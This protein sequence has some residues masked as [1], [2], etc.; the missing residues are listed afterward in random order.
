MSTPSSEH[1][2]LAVAIPYRAVV[3]TASSMPKLI[4]DMGPAAAFAWDELF[5]GQLRNQH[6]RPA[7]RR[8]IEQFL[9]W[10]A[11]HQVPIEMVT[12]GMI[13]AFMDSVEGGIPKKKLTMAALRRFFDTLVMRHVIV[14]NPALSVRT[15]RYEVV[16]GLTPEITPAQIRQLLASIP[17]NSDVDR[18]DAAILS[19]LIY[20]AARAGAVAK[21][22]RKHL[23]HDGTQWVLRFEEKGGK[24]REIPV[25]HDLELVLWDY[26]NQSGLKDTDPNAPLFRSG[27]AR[28]GRLTGECVTGTDICRMMK[29]RLAAAGQPTRLS[30]HSFRVATITDLLTQGVS[31]EDVQYLAGHAD[32][33]TTRLYDRRQR[34]ITRNVVERITL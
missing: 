15:E 10:L 12:P 20:T 19:T 14:L 7:Y 2:S 5:L 22:R 6:T 13:G 32:P 8:A 27:R 3:R 28:T 18:R 17:C 26:L 33:R 16:E 34:R 29:R 24:L 31:L 30:P 23:S 9:A 1:G 25:R 11:P 21:L 4:S